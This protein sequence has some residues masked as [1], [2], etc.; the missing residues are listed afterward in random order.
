[1]KRKN[2]I[3]TE[4]MAMGYLS[5][6]VFEAAMNFQSDMRSEL[7]LEPL[8]HWNRTCETPQWSKNICRNF[9]KTIF[10]PLRKLRPRRTVNWQN[11]GR[12]V[13]IGERYVT[14]VTKDVPRIFKEDGFDKM[15]EKRWQRIKE[16]LGLDQMR[17]Y[18]LKMLERPVSDKI[19]DEELFYLA[20]EKQ[21][22]DLE[23]MKQNA[24]ALAGEQ[25]A[26][27]RA[28]FLKGLG[29]GFTMFLN[30]ESDFSGDD[31]RTNI[32]MELLAWQHDIEKMQK[33][34][35]PK[36]NQHLIGELK[37]LPEFKTRTNEWF[38]DVF[39]DIKL[40]I[41]RRGRPPQYS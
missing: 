3:R 31:R 22:A 15:S 6:T 32:H 17:K 1:M 10:K 7:H 19:A 20:F 21:F 28:L 2:K 11:F 41:G 8:P 35:L 9:G 4:V 36:N 25:T 33:S 39:K 5:P 29:N 24:F 40:S 37:K 23:R 13:G 16:R 14:F 30:E 27:K 12:L 26:K 34:V 38:K 18:F